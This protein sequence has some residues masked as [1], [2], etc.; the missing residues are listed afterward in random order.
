MMPLYIAGAML[1]CDCYEYL[2]IHLSLTGSRA[3][4]QGCPMGLR[5]TVSSE[6]DYASN[7]FIFSA[8]LVHIKRSCGARDFSDEHTP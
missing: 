3:I 7:S 1:D 8:D 2:A 6:A 4:R 5:L